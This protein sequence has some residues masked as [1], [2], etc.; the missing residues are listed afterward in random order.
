MRGI[1][2]D[3][4][5]LRA[6]LEEFMLDLMYDL[7]EAKDVQ[8]Y[9]ITDKVVLGEEPV[10]KKTATNN[11]SVRTNQRLRTIVASL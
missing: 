7:P 1:G 3:Y 2:S 5:A 8:K 10:K 11:S 6:V 9:T 4:R